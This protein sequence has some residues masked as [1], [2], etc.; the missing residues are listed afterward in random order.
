MPSVPQRLQAPSQQVRMVSS[1][2]VPPLGSL[3]GI[4]Q[5]GHLR[6]PQPMK[7]GAGL[8][9]AGAAAAAGSGDGVGGAGG[10][11]LS[12]VQKSFLTMSLPVHGL[13]PAADGRPSLLCHTLQVAGGPTQFNI[14]PR[15]FGSACMHGES[16]PFITPTVDSLW[17]A[18]STQF[19]VIVTLRTHHVNPRD[20]RSHASAAMGWARMHNSRETASTDMSGCAMES[21]LRGGPEGASAVKRGPGQLHA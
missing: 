11:V 1:R 3:S 2:Q 6:S 9:G 8:A 7:A 14:E 16:L 12:K 19:E 4:S 20:S 18:M 21:A 13:E 15:D 10:A 17:R 5:H